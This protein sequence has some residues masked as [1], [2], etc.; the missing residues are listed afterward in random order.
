MEG[1]GRLQSA[2]TLV[3]R[4]QCPLRRSPSSMPALSIPSAR[5]KRAAGSWRWTGSSRGSAPAVTR[6]QLPARGASR[7]LQGRRGRAGSHRHARL[8]RRARGRAS[9]DDRERKRRRRGRRRHEPRHAPR[10]QSAGRRSGGGR[11]HPAPRARRREGPRLSLGGADQGPSGPRD[12][13]DR[14]S[15]RGRRDRLLRRRRIR[16]PRR[17]RC[18]AP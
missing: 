1:R 6:D 8:R 3:N 10:H 14:S 15:G 5:R 13:R 17:R 9:R 7:R 16:S 4:R 2:L 11:L 18:A 12:R